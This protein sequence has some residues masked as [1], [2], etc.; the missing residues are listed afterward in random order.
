M[1]GMVIKGFNPTS[2]EL[3]YLAKDPLNKSPF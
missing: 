2:E 3:K 1:A